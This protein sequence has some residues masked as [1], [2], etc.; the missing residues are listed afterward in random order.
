MYYSFPSQADVFFRYIKSDHL[1]PTC[2]KT[3]NYYIYS[4]ICFSM[5]RSKVHAR[6]QKMFPGGGSEEE[7]GFGGEGE[8]GEA[9]FSGF[10][11]VNFINFHFSDTPPTI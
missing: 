8:L 11:C 5:I 7:L 1:F 3:T 10:Y 4:V 2:F 6:I 9:Y